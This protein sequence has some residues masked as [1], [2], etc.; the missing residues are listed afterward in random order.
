MVSLD[1][2]EAVVAPARQRP[3][4]E[5]V[6][7]TQPEGV[8]NV[9]VLDRDPLV[10]YGLKALLDGTEGFACP[11]AYAPPWVDETNPDRPPDLSRLAGTDVILMDLC[12]S[13]TRGVEVVREVGRS[14]PGTAVVVFASPEDEKLIFEVL[15]A[16]VQG[17]LSKPMALPKILEA[18]REAHQ[19]GSPMSSFIANRVVKLFRAGRV[20][21]PETETLSLTPRET[22]VL[23]GLAEGR[24]YKE[25]A[26]DFR[27]SV[28][29]VRFH[30]R[31]LYEKL[32]AN[33]QAEAVAKG[34]R[35]GL[36]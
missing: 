18:L 19:G 7:K 22:A 23:R 34:L 13:G 26:E 21:S 5:G 29:T 20:R 1:T 8:I 36:I 32:Q 25:I 14:M 35:M 17:C 3:P 4:R 9:V 24:S 11:G 12:E 31:N 16:G 30:I 10:R 33:S 2:P 6:A 28:N 15:C 27:T